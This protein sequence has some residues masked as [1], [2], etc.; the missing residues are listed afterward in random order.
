MGSPK[1]RQT[2]KRGRRTRRQWQNYVTSADRAAP[3]SCE[4]GCHLRAW[5]SWRNLRYLSRDAL[6]GLGLQPML[7][8][9]LRATFARSE[10]RLTPELL[11][12]SGSP[13]NP[14]HPGIFVALNLPCPILGIAR[15]SI[16][17]LNGRHL[18][19]AG[20]CE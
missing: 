20:K 9:N 12:S 2:G 4:I 17:G 11:F 1:R 6:A 19:E 14:Y 15:S 7:R 5:R 16:S 8:A 13:L 18:D 10:C 3:P